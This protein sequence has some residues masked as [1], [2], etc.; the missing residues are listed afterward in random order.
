LAQQLGI[1]VGPTDE[2]PWGLPVT[3]EP[4][5]RGVPLSKAESRIP[6]VLRHFDSGLRFRHVPFRVVTLNL[7][8]GLL[9]QAIAQKCVTGIGF[10]RALVF[11]NPTLIRH[12]ARI[13][14]HGDPNT[15]II[16][17]DSMG[18][19]PAQHIVEWTALETAV[20]NIDDGFWLIGSDVA[21]NLEYA[22]ALDR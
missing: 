11:H 10:N 18:R 13:V 5:L 15:V 16:L 14:P 22:P 4:S 19:P 2:N 20:Y 7:F 3:P 6:A 9:D 1:C 21:L 8:A 12:V 17:D